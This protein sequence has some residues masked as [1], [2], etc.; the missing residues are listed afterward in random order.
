MAYQSL[1]VIHRCRHSLFSRT[2]ARGAEVVA[3][4]LEPKR[5][6][7][8]SQT[9]QR[10]PLPVGSRTAPSHRSRDASRGGDEDGVTVIRFTAEALRDPAILLDAEALSDP[11]KDRAAGLLDL[12]REP[13]EVLLGFRVEGDGPDA[14]LE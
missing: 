10:D 14:A 11:Q 1:D 5:A 4:P 3:P 9:A 13:L 6:L 2:P 12:L 8:Y 7:Q